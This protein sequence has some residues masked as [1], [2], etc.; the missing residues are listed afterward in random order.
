MAE[1]AVKSSEVRN[2]WSSFVDDVLYR[3]PKFVQRNERDSIVAMNLEIVKL[4]TE[5]LRYSVTLEHDEEANEW[6]AS[7]DQSWIVESAETEH[8]A[9]SLYLESYL[10]WSVDY[11]KEFNT[12]YSAPNLKAQ[13]PYILKALVQETVDNLR[14]YTDV[15]YARP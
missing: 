1:I 5:S 10:E 13:L 4:I 14:A 3:A 8:E 6:I 15:E 12:N 9:V 7:S 11:L 2:N